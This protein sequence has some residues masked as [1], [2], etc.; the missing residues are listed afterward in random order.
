LL[1]HVIC[2]FLVSLLIL[3]NVFAQQ[4]ISVVKGVV[5]DKETGEALAGASVY[6]AETTIGTMAQKKGDYILE[7]R[8]PGFYELVV[9]MVG[10][11]IQKRSMQIQP[12]EKYTVDIKMAQKALEV[13]TV[14]VEGTDQ[15]DW[16]T[17]LSVFSRKFLGSLEPSFDCTIENREI[18]NFKWRGDTLTA[19]ADKPVI[20]INN[21]LGYKVICEIVS[22]RYVPVSTYQ[23]YSI[24]SRFEELVP[25]DNSQKEKWESNREKVFNGSPVHFLWALKNNMLRTEKFIV[26]LTSNTNLKSTGPF[27]EIKSWTDIK[28]QEQFLDE[29]ILSFEGYLKIKYNDMQVSFVK[30]R[31]PLFTIDSNGIADN[32]LPFLCFGYWSNM[33]VADMLPRGYLPERLKN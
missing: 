18:I 31:F 11:E 12:G 27:K 22:Y 19:W 20:I 10:Y 24:F 3:S 25:K 15:G 30:A 17:S 33:G 8:K 7:V 13:K 28:Y 5:T 26:V 14:E 9:S 32:H 1:K 4:N 23:E 29:P 6:F 16:R 2:Y 21:F